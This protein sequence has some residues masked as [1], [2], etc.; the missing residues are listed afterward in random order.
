MGGSSQTH[1]GYF[2]EKVD[3]FDLNEHQIPPNRK[4]ELYHAS[5]RSAFLA[6]KINASDQRCAFG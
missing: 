2:D 5:F 1:G 3:T 4:S 6:G